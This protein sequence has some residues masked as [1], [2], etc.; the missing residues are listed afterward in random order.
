MPRWLSQY[1]PAVVTAA[2]YSMM[3]AP[4]GILN[5][6]NIS[7]LQADGRFTLYNLFRLGQP[8]LTVGLL[9]LFWLLDWL[10]P[11]TAAL[12][13]LGPLVPLSGLILFV[14]LRE[15]LPSILGIWQACGRLL[16][17]GVRSYGVDILGTLG[18]QIDRALVVAL[19]SA[20]TLGAYVVYISVARTLNTVQSAVVSVLFPRA[21]GRSIAEVLKLTGRAASLT[22]LLAAA[23]ATL[24][25]VLGQPLI[26]LVYGAEFTRHIWAFR[27]LCVE[28]VLT[29]VSWVLS[30][31]FMATGRPGV[32][33]GTQSAGLVAAV[34]LVVYMG[35][36]R[37]LPGLA[38]GLA[39]A[40]LVRLAA[41]LI[42]FPVVLHV[43]PPVF[44]PM[45]RHP[46]ALVRKVRNESD[47]P[48]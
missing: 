41:V 28:A 45:A 31:A 11:L 29:G 5:L 32:I 40:G 3:V 18:A 16:S 24:L 4:F 36:S 15:S 43:R 9:G 30:Q 14:V 22:A 17:Y 21:S 12:A 10:S 8:M 19:F 26:R 39:I 1:S 34:P 47:R 35:L 48:K 46:V 2:Q 13:Y 27:W 37:G 20:S 7:V 42:A 38:F 33:T 6:V 25:F 44:P 23:G